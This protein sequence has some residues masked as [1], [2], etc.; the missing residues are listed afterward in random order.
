MDN[1]K[2][3]P[4]HARQKKNRAVDMIIRVVLII[5]V[6]AFLFSGWKM[7]DEL[8][9]EPGRNKKGLEEYREMR[10]TA[11]SRTNPVSSAP[12]AE[13]KTESGAETESAP[14]EILPSFAELYAANPDIGGWLTI[15][16]TELDHPVF[17]TPMNQNYYLARDP[18][19]SP[20][21]Y[22]SLFLSSF[23]TLDPQAQVLVMYGHNMENDDL[24]FGQLNAYKKLSFLKEH[25]TF[26][27]DTVYREGEWKV[28]AVARASTNELN[29]FPYNC[30]QY[31][32]D[33][34]FYAFIR[35]ARLQSMYHIDDDV[36]PSDSLLV[37]STCDYLYFGD[38]LVIV[39]RRLRDGEGAVDTARYEVN[40]LML[41]PATYYTLSYTTG[42]RPGNEAL[43]NAYRDFY[44]E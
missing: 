41:W 18:D 39:A 11:S 37:M 28:I 26:T 31:D 29:I 32:T 42:T 36:T 21:K 13:S 10:P 25:P 2:H 40:N 35:Q 43:A 5:S 30:T 16:D 7:L 4:K 24:M 33:E 19:G 1:E 9:I 44:G 8:V 12:P 15:P 6:A 23:S 22:G 34:E 27:F 17:Y 14:A 3:G 20:N 38:R